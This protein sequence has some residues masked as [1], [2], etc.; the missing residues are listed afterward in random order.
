G[1]PWAEAVKALVV[2]VVAAAACYAVS[3]LVSAGS[4]RRDVVALSAIGATWVV[5][6][7]AGLWVTRSRLW[8]ELRRGKKPMPMAEPQAVIERTEGGVEP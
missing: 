3:L 6:V 7:A 8:G 1:L 5:V 4:W 2:A